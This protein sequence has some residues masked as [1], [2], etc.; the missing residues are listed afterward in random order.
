MQWSDDSVVAKGCT[1]GRAVGAAT[2]IGE[3]G[4][5]I[6]DQAYELGEEVS[7]YDV[8]VDSLAGR[9]ALTYDTC[10]LLTATYR[11]GGRPVNSSSCPVSQPV[12]RMRLFTQQWHRFPRRVP[13]LRIRTVRPAVITVGS[14]MVWF[15]YR[16]NIRLATI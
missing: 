9:T 2:T 4:G 7:Q 12:S 11:M 5:E 14:V 8:D 13:W 15:G 1:N 10:S 3:V 16:H 6:H